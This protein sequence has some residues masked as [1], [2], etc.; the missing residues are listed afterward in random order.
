[1]RTKIQIRACNLLHL[2]HGGQ[3]GIMTGKIFEYLGARR[4]ILFILGDN[5]CEDALL[6]EIQ[7]GV[8]CRNTEEAAA[9]LLR[10]YRQW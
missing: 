3:K 6:K 5:D 1:M 8:I 10:W 4:P 2:A 7:A 9:Q